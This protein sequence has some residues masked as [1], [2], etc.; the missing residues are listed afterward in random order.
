MSPRE[1]RRPVAQPSY[2]R[3][4]AVVRCNR[5]HPAEGLCALAVRCDRARSVFSRPKNLLCR[6]AAIVPGLP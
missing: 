6:G 3:S 4:P 2:R 5:V 1:P